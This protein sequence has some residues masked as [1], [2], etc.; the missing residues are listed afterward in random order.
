M[1]EQVT[2][3]T[4]AV[5][6]LTTTEFSSIEEF[7]LNSEITTTSETISE[8]TTT[9]PTAEDA[10]LQSVQNIETLLMYFFGMA[11]ILIVAFICSIIIK[12]FFGE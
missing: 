5:T 7:L 2:T 1:E 6:E 8:T 11:V 4:E 3:V 9:I 10:V 12:T